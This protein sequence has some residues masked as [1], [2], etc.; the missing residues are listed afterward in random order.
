MPDIFTDTNGRPR[1]L[2]GTA[3][4]TGSARVAEMAGRVGFNIAWIEM[5]HASAPDLAAA[6]ALCVATEAG[7]AIPLIRTMGYRREHILQALEVGGR[8]IVV[9][10]VNHAAAAREIVRWGKFRPLGERG[11]NTR[12]RAAGFGIEPMSMERMNEENWLFPQIETLEAVRNLDEIIAVQ[13]LGGLFIGPGDLSCD[14]GCPGDMTDSRL[15]EIVC[16]CIARARAA[17]LHASIL[18]GPG[19]LLDA[20]IAAGADLCII[21][22]D[23]GAIIKVWREQVSQY[24]T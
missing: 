15:H 18:V 24:I 4:N 17:G 9:P 5:E 20:A 11:Y 1:V 14:L 21:A 7:G 16:D 2:W 13:G 6:E 19:P 22:S 23:M 10:M 8:V 3:I 12:S